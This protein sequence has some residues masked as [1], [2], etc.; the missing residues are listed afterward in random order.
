MKPTRRGVL[1][2]NR[3][4]AILRATS[5]AIAF[6]G[7]IT[8]SE[9]QPAAP[10]KYLPTWES[11]KQHPVPDWFHDAK[12]GLFPVWGIYSVPGWAPPT[13]ELGKVDLN[14]WF[15]RNPYA[16][17]YWNSMKIKDSP[18]WQRHVTTYGADFQYEDF[19]PIFNREAKK[20]DPDKWAELFHS[21]GGKYVVFT[22]KFHDGYPLW[23][24][25]VLNPHR[26]VDQLA[27][28]RDYVGDLSQAVRARGMKM[29]LYY[30]GGLD[31]TF[32]G[33]PIA[34]LAD[35]KLALP[36]SAEYAR[37]ADAHYGELI[38]RYHADILWN[39]INYPKLGDLKTIFSDYFARFP[40]GLVNDRF[41]VEFSDFTTPEYTHYREIASKK[42][43]ATRGVGFSFGYNQAEGPEH[44]LSVDQ[45][46]KLLVDV[47]S[48]NGNLLLA[49][50]PR[51]DGSIP[52][53]Q[54]DRV[55]ALG[56]WLRVN[57]DAI[58]GTRPWA[59]AEGRTTD[60]GEV[61]FTKKSGSLYAVLV[62]KPTGTRV[63]IEFL[64]LAQSGV[65]KMLGVEEHLKWSQDGN[66]LAITLPDRLPGFSAWSLKIS[67]QPQDLAHA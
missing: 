43:E 25:C 46:V 39:D 30:S 44:C 64:S 5:G 23:P 26:R 66:N 61:R 47:V 14:V 2:G 9:P 33:A 13:G 18:T 50:G 29:G 1:D 54:E 42:W 35:M 15:H 55:R 6:H 20:W 45:L 63:A 24:S 7:A 17:W 16:E 4:S 8:P 58:Y 65:V 22:T 57:G 56:K 11:I 60:G 28:Q 31:W 49:V 62:A 48:K 21:A 37:Y 12:L 67:P 40:E 51:A 19:I 34:S 41:G 10:T 38:D 53:T 59:R 32:E 52:E 36:Q 3:Q 27:A